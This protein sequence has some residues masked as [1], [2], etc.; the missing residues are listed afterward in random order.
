MQRREILVTGTAAAVGLAAWRQPAHADAITTSIGGSGPLSG[1]PW[2]SGV[3]RDKSVATFEDWR[4]RKADLV[5]IW[6]KRNTWDDV[7]GGEDDDSATGWFSQHWRGVAASGRP[8][9]I[10]WPLLP[11]AADARKH[12]DSWPAA[13]RGEFDPYYARF[14]KKLQ[15]MLEQTGRRG[16]IV[17][18]NWE[19][20]G[21]F[22]QHSIGDQVD[23]WR[24]GFRRAVDLLHR[25]VPGVLIDWSSVK[26]GKAKEGN[27]ELY[28]GGDWVDIVGVDYYDRQPASPTPEMFDKNSARTFR[29][30]PFGLKAWYEFARSLGKPLSLPEW[31]VMVDPGKHPGAGG[32]NATYMMKMHQFIDNHRNAIAY[33]NY[34]DLGDSKIDPPAEAGRAADVYRRLWGQGS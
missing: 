12:E 5:T 14:A 31:G 2:H 20:N 30:G 25:H 13:A 34:F 21:N 23:E 10:S 19:G 32:D 28:P 11:I 15:R 16:C 26:K 24:T 6:G 3:C 1:L 9:S 17:R 33:E 29:G 8:L 18:V 22:Y 27:Q 4:G 7:A